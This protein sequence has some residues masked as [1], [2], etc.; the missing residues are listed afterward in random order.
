MCTC[1]IFFQLHNIHLEFAQIQ[2]EIMYLKTLVFKISNVQKNPRI[3]FEK[4]DK[5]IFK[6]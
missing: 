6:G 5:Y 3:C 2:M 4:D 1:N